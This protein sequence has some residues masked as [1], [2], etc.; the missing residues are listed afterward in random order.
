MLFR[1]L[2]P[3]G[4]C[5]AQVLNELPARYPMIAIERAVIM[6][7]HIHLLLRITGER[8][9]HEAP[10]QDERTRSVLSKAIGYLKA[11]SSKEI[12]RFRTGEIIWQRSY[13]DHIIRSETDYR[14]I[15][16]YIANNPARWAEDRFHP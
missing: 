3:E 13:Y 2:T 7:N 16:E 15:A 9:L 4:Q 12:H 5:V 1:S 6:P 14:E 11:N 8:A 10:L